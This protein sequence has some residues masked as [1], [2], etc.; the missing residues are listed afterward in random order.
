MII[1]VLSTAVMYRTNVGISHQRNGYM[2]YTHDGV[3]SIMKN[4]IVIF[5]KIGIVEDIQIK[6]VSDK[7]HI[8]SYLW[9]LDFL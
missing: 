8:F 7:Y 3:F 1:A 5:R 6:T 9:I 4:E 2:L